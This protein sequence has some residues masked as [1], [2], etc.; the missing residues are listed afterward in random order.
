MNPLVLASAI[1]KEESP[2][3]SLFD[4]LYP[5]IEVDDLLS[6]NP[7]ALIIWGGEDI[8]PSLYN[9]KPALLYT[10]APAYL[11]K[12]DLIE[13]TLAKQ[14]IESNIPIIGICRGAQLMCAL[15][16]GSVI[17]HVTGHCKWTYH[18]METNKGDIICTN[19]VH[20]QMM[21]PFKVDQYEL[22]AWS[23]KKLSLNYIGNGGAHVKEAYSKNFKEPEVIWFPKTK[24][25]CIQGHPE[26]STALPKFK[27]Y[28]LELITKYILVNAKPA[29]PSA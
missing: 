26:F 7:A 11:S 12:R 16:G 4:V 23:K 19:S 20:H 13:S 21:N 14:A 6:C 15:S 1:Y 8:S 28:I 24:A 10:D 17:Q 18:E 22:L 5:V 25:L 9:Q 3:D 29:N 2:I 27:E